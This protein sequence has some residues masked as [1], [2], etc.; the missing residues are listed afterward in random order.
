[1]SPIFRY[2]SGMCA[3][4]TLVS[5]TLPLAATPPLPMATASA[6]RARVSGAYGKLPLTFEANEGQ[7]DRAVQFLCRGPGYTLFL[8]SAEAVLSLSRQ[9]H[10]AAVVGL[11]LAGANRHPVLLGEVP[12][13]T[14]SNYFIGNN[15]GQWHTGIAHFARVR[16]EGIYPGVDLVYRG[17]QRQL[18]YDFVVSPGGDPGRIRLSFQGANPIT[19]G[20]HGELILHTAG[21]ELVQ[22]APTLYQVAGHRRKRV[23]GHY[24][25]LTHPPAKQGGGGVNRQ[26]GFILG[27]YNRARPLIIDP[28][29]V[30]STFLG[31]SSHD[32]ASGIAVDS[33][34]NAYV[35]GQTSSSA[36]PGVSGSSLQPA[37]GGGIFGGDAFVTKINAAGT[38]IVY[39]TFLGGGG[40]DAATGIAVDGAGNAYVTGATESTT[41]PG[42]S[43]NSIQ[44]AYGGAGDAFVTKINATGTAILYSTFLGGSASDT[45]FGIAVDS[46]GSAYL[47]GETESTNFPGVSGSSI[48]PAYGGGLTDAFVT[49]INAAGTAIVYSTFL[50]GSG[51]EG[52]HGIAV[53]AAENAYV[54]GT[55]TSNIFPGVSGNSIQPARGGGLDDAF[56][57]KINAAGTA[58]VYSTFLG[59]SGINLAYGIAVDAAGNVY[60]TGYTGSTTFP[61]VSGSSIQPVNAGGFEDAFVTKINAA[62]TAIAYSTFLGGEGDDRAFGIAVD[63]AGNAYVTGDTSS[64]NFPIVSGSSIQP[65]YGGGLADA[66]VAKINAAGTA[67]VYSTFLGGNSNDHANG[68]AVDGHGNV[69]VVGDT[70]STT[71]PGVSETS[72]QPANGGSDDA[73]VA[74]ISNDGLAFSTISPCRLVDTRNAAGPLSGPALLPGAVRTFALTGV[75]GVPS[76]ATALSINV[77]VTQPTAAGDLRLLPGDQSILPLVSTINYSPGQ[78]RANN[79]IAPLAFDG[80]GSLKVKTDSAGSVHLIVDVNGY[81]Q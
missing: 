69:Y 63:G 26:V 7:A 54:T 56:V 6:T 49:K 3:I 34:G 28:V 33:E 13:V 66:F 76:S 8:T 16:A 58:I 81:F 52:G 65:A 17:N 73:F 18:E 78:T 10:E 30:Y 74:K 46:S 29:L 64:A 60:V 70:L 41:F 48:Q 59:G 1:V 2:A 22:P 20:A 62:G 11:R 72:I 53:D 45:A 15:P 79:A 9:G 27:R 38:A 61:G 24:V 21:G 80:S 43:A 5:G 77:T 36:F 50:G 44:P 68:V 37:N 71:F 57:T 75:C 47:T 67:I 42:V 55:T 31:G 4:A 14:Q 35:A 51:I 32:Q 25:L 23:E 19:I 40:N 39:S 12:R